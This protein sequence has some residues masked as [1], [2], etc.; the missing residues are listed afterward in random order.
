MPAICGAGQVRPGATRA[1]MRSA[2]E[3]TGRRMRATASR[4]SASA[5]AA[6]AGLQRPQ[7]LHAVF[8]DRAAA[9]ALP[10]AL[11]DRVRG[12]ADA[13]LLRAGEVGAQQARAGERMLGR[14]V[15][16]Q[17]ACERGTHRLAVKRHA[18]RQHADEAAH[19]A[20]RADEHARGRFRVA[21]GMLEEQLAQIGFERGRRRLARDRGNVV[22][23]MRATAGMS[24]AVQVRISLICE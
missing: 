13:E 14:I 16:H 18:H 5:I 12:L 9:D 1:M 15:D 23:N 4:S 3:A 22:W 20:V 10:H 17:R 11:G 2:S 7:P 24:S 6:P 8:G 21:P 19:P